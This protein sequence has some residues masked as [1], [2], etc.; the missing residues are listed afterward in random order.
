MSLQLLM[1]LFKSDC[2]GCERTLMP[3]CAVVPREKW[4]KMFVFF[5]AR[6]YHQCPS[7]P[8]LGTWPTG[9]SSHKYKF[10]PVDVCSLRSSGTLRRAVWYKFTDV[11][12]ILSAPII[13]ALSPDKLLPEDS[14]QHSR[15][16]PSLYSPS[17][18]REALRNFPQFV[19]TN[20]GIFSS[21]RTPPRP[22]K[23]FSYL[24]NTAIF[25][26]H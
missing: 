11:S 6:G 7:K 5:V 26:T 18:C 15:R 21:N 8:Q 2:S 24:S 3:R 17:W 14:A 19:Q 23:Q 16:Q 20:V 10:P 9:F 4:I 25:K 1:T 13:R 12:Y 22:S